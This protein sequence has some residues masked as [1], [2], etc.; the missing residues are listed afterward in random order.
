LLLVFVSVHAFAA[1]NDRRHMS[2]AAKSCARALTNEPTFDIRLGQLVITRGHSL[3]IGSEEFL[4]VRL[5]P[6]E[7]SMEYIRPK[8]KGYA[9]QC[10]EFFTERPAA[11]LDPDA[12][13]EAR[14]SILLD[15]WKLSG[16]QC[17][18]AAEVLREFPHSIETLSKSAVALF[19]PT[20]P[21]KAPGQTTTIVVRGDGPVYS[22]RMNLDNMESVDIRPGINSEMEKLVESI[23]EHVRDCTSKRTPDS[24]ASRKSK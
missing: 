9:E 2:G 12:N 7:T 23:F 3:F 22:V 6:T 10:I 19:N 20:P 18:K 15:H 13:F 4:S 11:L 8:G 14:G 21:S 16:A 1:D 24:R 5:L 17:P